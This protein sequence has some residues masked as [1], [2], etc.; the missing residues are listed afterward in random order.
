MDFLLL[1]Y[2]NFIAR[3]IPPKR[4]E[5]LTLTSDVFSNAWIQVF[6]N[7]HNVRDIIKC[8][9]VCKALKTL[10]LNERVWRCR[11]IGFY[12]DLNISVDSIEF[13][14]PITE[15]TNGDHKDKQFT[16]RKLDPSCQFLLLEPPLDP[17]SF[18][19][20][21]EQ[22]RGLIKNRKGSRIMTSINSNSTIYKIRKGQYNKV[23]EELF[24]SN[25][26]LAAIMKYEN[27][28]NFSRQ[29][30]LKKKSKS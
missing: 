15:S 28:K 27:V 6:I 21:A 20:S 17:L 12:G 10:V 26:F 14:S 25:R 22:L 18:H 9:R 4:C 16:P 30:H 7:I 19:E 11:V 24:T 5:N 29:H 1:L 8:M 13:F 2:N 3:C 23:A